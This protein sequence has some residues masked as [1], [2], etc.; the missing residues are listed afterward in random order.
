L[1]LRYVTKGALVISEEAI[2][3]SPSLR[4]KKEFLKQNEKVPKRGF[5]LAGSWWQRTGIV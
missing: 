1:E 2:A 4:G 3:F 5:N